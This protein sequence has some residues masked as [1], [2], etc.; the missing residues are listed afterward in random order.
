MIFKH[1]IYLCLQFI[2]RV[3]QNGES[4][5]VYNIFLFV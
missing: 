3:F 2:C 5:G 4:E 1:D